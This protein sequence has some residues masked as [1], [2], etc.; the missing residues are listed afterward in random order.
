VFTGERGRGG[1]IL[2]VRV[3]YEKEPVLGYIEQAKK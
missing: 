2:K 3:A 1:C